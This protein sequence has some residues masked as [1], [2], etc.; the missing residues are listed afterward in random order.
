[1]N[2]IEFAP[3]NTHGTTAASKPW[4]QGIWEELANPGGQ[5]TEKH[6][7]IVSGTNSEPR[8][9]T[10]TISN[11]NLGLLQPF[12]TSLFKRAGF[13]FIVIDD[14]HNYISSF[15]SSIIQ[16]PQSNSLTYLVPSYVSAMTDHSSG[17]L[18]P[19][20]LDH[21]RVRPK[22]R[23]TVTLDLNFRGRPKALPIDDLE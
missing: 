21:N 23:F 22:R 9:S 6:R 16:A 18:E 1:M 14:E 10:M 15:V 17:W 20:M 7:V 12:S 8:N 4:G 5:G 19:E 11:I 13:N 2:A 3:V